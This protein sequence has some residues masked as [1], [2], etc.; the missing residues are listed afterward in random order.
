MNER[1]LTTWNQ[2]RL[3]GPRPA[4]VEVGPDSLP[5]ATVR[6]GRGPAIF[7]VVAQIQILV[8]GGGMKDGPMSRTRSAD[9]STGIPLR[10]SIEEYDCASPITAR[11]IR[12]GQAHRAMRVKFPARFFNRLTRT[13]TGK[14]CRM[15]FSTSPFESRRSSVAAQV[16][17]GDAA[18]QL[19]MSSIFNHCLRSRS[20]NRASL[21][22]HVPTNLAA[23]NTDT[24]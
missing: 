16:A 14:Q 7:A 19:E 23:Y 1:S 11:L 22:R 6:Q 21:A 10:P 13:S 8:A 4:W 17:L 9:G 15:I 12:N 18:Y 2:E 24:L 20:L 3:G 5:D